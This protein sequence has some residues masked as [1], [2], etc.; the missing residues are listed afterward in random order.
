MVK[1]M[2]RAKGGTRRVRFVVRL[3]QAEEV[4]LTGDFSGWDPAGI[5]L[6]HGAQ[7]T[8][9]ATLDLAPG[10]HEYRL[11]VDGDWR[12]DPEAEDRVPN[13]FG[14]LNSVLKVD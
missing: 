4:I 13:P 1:A 7:D 3:P 9:Y 8:W 2:G 12:D 10:A 6:H 11:R 5:P 14:T